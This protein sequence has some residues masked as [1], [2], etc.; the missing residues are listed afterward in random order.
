[1]QAQKRTASELAAMPRPRNV[2]E[3]EILSFWY[4][5]KALH[6]SRLIVRENYVEYE[7]AEKYNAYH[8]ARWLFST[9]SCEGYDYSGAFW[10]HVVGNLFCG[11]IAAHSYG[12]ARPHP[13]HREQKRLE[14]LRDSWLSKRTGRPRATLARLAEQI[15]FGESTTI[16]G[17]RAHING[18]VDAV[19]NVSVAA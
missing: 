1:M 2:A 12:Q 19:L 13:G 18:R 3:L 6:F 11:G 9:F 5:G 10:R 4:F 8:G 15:G 17:D 7:V 16:R 14:E